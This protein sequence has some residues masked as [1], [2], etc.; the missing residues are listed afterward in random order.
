MPITETCIVNNVFQLKNV[1]S[2]VLAVPM[3]AILSNVSFLSTLRQK[4]LSLNVFSGREVDV[5]DSMGLLPFCVFK[6]SYHTV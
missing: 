5:K 6:Y 2:E 4:K 3:I 1:W